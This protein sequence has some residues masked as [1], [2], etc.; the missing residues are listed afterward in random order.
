MKTEA[1]IRDKIASMKKYVDETNRKGLP[2]YVIYTM[3]NQ[4]MD[5]IEILEWVLE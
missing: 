3:I 2:E 5:K 4:R 1:E